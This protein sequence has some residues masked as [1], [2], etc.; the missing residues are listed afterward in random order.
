MDFQRQSHVT[1]YQLTSVDKASLTDSAVWDWLAKMR[2]SMHKYY[3][4]KSVFHLYTLFSCIHIFGYARY[5]EYFDRYPDIYN[6][7][8]VFPCD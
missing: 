7:I 3:S 1:M 6:Q 2:Y 8:L 5:E 4:Q